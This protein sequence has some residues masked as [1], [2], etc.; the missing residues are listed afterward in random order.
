MTNMSK[1]DT[2]KTD[3]SAAE[4]PPSGWIDRYAPGPARPYLKLMRLDRP[5]GGWLLLFPCWWSLALAQGLTASPWPELRLIALFTVGAVVMRGAGCTW[6]DITDREFDARVERTRTRPIPS[7]AVSVPRAFAFLALQLLIGLAILLSFNRFTVWLGVASL[8]LVFT[9]PFMKRF[10]YW[11]QLFLGLTFN[12]GALMGWAAVA[13]SLAPAPLALYLGGVLWTLG[14]DTIYAHQDKEDDAF[15]GIKSTA[16][17]FGEASKLWVSG[18]YAAAAAAIALAGALAGLA[19][20][21]YLALGLGAGQLLW[22]V[23][24]VELD[25]PADCLA[26]FKSNRLIG[27]ILLAGIGAGQWAA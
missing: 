11:P 26:K 19:W 13:G 12:W 8:A 10:T 23:A 1:T 21:F 27:W 5:I 14:Y 24:R 9:Y 2:P 18:F 6:N 7:G 4:V 16:L 15:I 17:K 3:S 20:P 22:Q 25:D